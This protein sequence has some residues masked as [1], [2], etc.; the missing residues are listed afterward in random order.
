MIPAKFGP[1]LYG[2]IL[3]GLMSLVVS[4]ISTLRAA[5]AVPGYF[6][7]WTQAWLTAWVFAFP[8][9]LVATPLVRRAVRLL[10]RSE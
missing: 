3:S 7:L 10:V 4:G 5:G 9:V 8:I 2:L 6:A 1:V